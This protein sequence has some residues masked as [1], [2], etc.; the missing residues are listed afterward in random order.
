VVEGNDLEESEVLVIGLVGVVIQL[1]PRILYPLLLSPRS[2]PEQ[3]L[4]LLEAALILHIVAIRRFGPLDGVGNVFSVEKEDGR[5]GRGYILSWL[6]CGG[7]NGMSRV[8]AW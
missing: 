7:A 1:Y 3:T 5:W 2:R 4:W 6:P 8:G